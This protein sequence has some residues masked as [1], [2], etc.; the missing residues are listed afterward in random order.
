VLEKNRG[1]LNTLARYS[2]LHKLQSATAVFNFSSLPRL[3]GNISSIYY[4]RGFGRSVLPPCHPYTGFGM[5]L[6][7]AGRFIY[8]QFAARKLTVSRRTLVAATFVES[9]LCHSGALS[10]V[11]VIFYGK[12]LFKIPP[13][14]WRLLTPFMLTSGGLGFIFDLYFCGTSMASRVTIL[15]LTEVS[16]VEIWN[17]T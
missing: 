11:R 9:V 13:D 6:R 1:A 5:L 14:I 10:A 17:G 3:Q 15:K 7:S 2:V 12:W 16:S 8:T 4:H